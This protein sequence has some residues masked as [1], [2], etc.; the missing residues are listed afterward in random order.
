[1]FSSFR[2]V[3]P[4]ITIFHRPSSPPSQNALNL[5]RSA[6][7]GPFPSNKASSPPLDFKL[8]VVEAPPTSD[9]LRTILSFVSPGQTASAASVF[10]SAHP[11]APS[12]SEV[13]QSVSRIHDIGAKNPNA[14][15][16]PIVVDWAAGKASIG[17][18]EG[19]KS[20]LEMLRKNR[21]GEL[22]KE[23]NVNQPKGWFS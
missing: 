22:P 1:M 23:E 3:V 2:R 20:F 11:S 19:V 9:Q 10:L 16:W 7:S 21:D 14:M 4:E 17:D 8:E 13:S 5:L 15:K 6:V 18:V 12:D